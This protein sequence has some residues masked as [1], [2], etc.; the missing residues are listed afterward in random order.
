MLRASWKSLLAR[1][2]S[3]VLSA[4]AIVLGTAFVGGSFTFTDMLS[5]AF[6]GIMSGSVGDVNV[7]P[8]SSLESMGMSDQTLTPADLAKVAAVDGVASAY[9]T[10][11][12]Q[13]AYLL[14]SNGKP[15]TMGAPG[16][17]TNYIDAPAAGGQTGLELLSGN[18]PRGPDEVVIDPD[19]L[20]KLNLSLGDRVRIYTSGDQGVVEKKVVGTAL[21]GS[22]GSTGGATYAIFDT[23]AAQQLFLNGKDA[24][25]GIWITTK[26]EADPQQV[27]DRVA[28]VIPSGW[29]AKTGQAIGEELESM[30]A[31]GMQFITYLLLVFAGIALLVG[32][33]LIVNT[34][35]ILVAQRARELALF[36]AMGASRGQVRFS[37]LFEALILGVIGSTL[38][39][40]LGFGL[41]FGISRIFSGIGLDISG[42]P[43]RLTPTAAIATYS[44]GILVTLVAASIPAIRASRVPPVAAMSGDYAT[45]ASGL[46]MRAV[47]GGALT[48]AGAAALVFGLFGQPPFNRLWLIGGGALAVLLGVAAISPIIGAP[49]IWLIGKVGTGLFGATGRLAELNSRR[50]PRRTAIT[51]SALMIGLALVTAFGLV[52]ASMKASTDKALQSSM[53]SDYVVQSMSGMPFSPAI[54]D[55]MEKVD[56]VAAVHRLRFVPAQMSGE[57]AFLGAMPPTSFDKILK[58]TMVQGSIGDFHRDTVLVLDTYATEKGW[59]LGQ[60][61]PAEVNGQKLS[62]KVAGIFSMEP[63]TGLSSVL[64][65]IDTIEAVGMRATDSFLAVDLTPGADAGAVKQ[66]LDKIVEPLPLVSVAD[67]QEYANAQAQ[68]LDLLLYLLY[69]LLGLAIVIAVFGIVNTL[70]LSIIER[71]REIG[72]LR[73]V[74]LTRGQV[75]RM[76]LLES[77]TI[78]LLGAALGIGLGL[79]FGF[80]LQRA[81]SEQG[82]TELALPW[83]QLGISAV[84]ALIVGVLAGVW[85][86]A[87][88]SRLD[89]L[90]AIAAE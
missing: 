25:H 74:G 32:S 11:G 83:A 61:L 47:L 12:A 18:P 65:T 75:R 1:K 35:T 58:Q 79:L 5:S 63:G 64:T 72:L 4:L 81:L 13:D 51:A 46:G 34:F 8:E 9:G 49:V 68:Q 41:A 37:V 28:A 27:A 48:A 50:N 16:I 82:L 24:Y 53:R 33:F 38:G 70:G 6:R 71:T 62:V 23:P 29:E 90:D 67:Q 54:G 59:T 26:A 44:V 89:V 78:S 80:A 22:K 7:Q 20:S 43:M 85:P 2:I 3:L 66:Q 57:S 19:S 69:A 10:V 42:T 30:L 73:A 36:R 45:G 55:D 76:V 60:T 52:A 17:G 15:L 87:R 77:T 86:A 21:Y 31:S 88:A 39:L 56:G 40:A 14:G 84:V